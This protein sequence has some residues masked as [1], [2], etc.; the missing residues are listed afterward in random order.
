[1]AG[2]IASPVRFGSGTAMQ[3]LAGSVSAF[4]AL[5][6]FDKRR[7]VATY[8]L[9]VVNR[10]HS[11]LICRTWVISRAGDAAL[12]YPVLFEIEPLSTNAM[13]VP[14]WPGDFGS[15][16]RAIAEI[17]GE[18]VQCIVEAPAPARFTPERPYAR[19]AAACVGIG[20]LALTIAGALNGAMP[21]IAAFAVPPEA[22]TGTTVRAE[23]NA[24]GAGTLSYSVLAPDGR[25]IQGGTV[26]DRSGELPI[27]LPASNAPSAY[28]VQMTMAGPLGAATETRVLNAVA[29]RGA[30]APQ[31]AGISVSP[32]VAKPGQS[33]NVAYSASGDDGYVRLMGDD[34]TIWAQQP[35]SHAGQTRLIVPP[36][37]ASQQ[38]KI[39]LHVTK[40][41]AAVQSVAGLLVVPSAASRSIAS[42]PQ[43]VGDD[44]PTTASSAASDAGENG[45][46]ALAASTVK[47]GATVHVHV[48][49]PRNG[50]RISLTDGQ[51]HEVT[52][53]NVGS[54]SSDITLT[55]PTVTAPTRYT[56]VASFT[57]GFG[58]ESVV[59]PLTVV[60]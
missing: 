41:R 47:S 17:A 3:T 43:I 22:L 15:F 51:S 28:T 20:L 8:M 46:F 31:I 40:G 52:G 29:G 9:R 59:E 13:Q 14:V 50:M 58:Q 60:P 37:T 53:L 1:M 2:A 18:G 57:D 7:G 19:I 35:F 23:Y 49:S 10:T 27:P 55:A 6:S 25:R 24:S 32:L 56:V 5:E 33:V 16:D 21:R 4:F 44:D 48:L 54:D 36:V 39:L 30:G 12:A 11:A 38:M 45:T 42:P 34:G 26:A